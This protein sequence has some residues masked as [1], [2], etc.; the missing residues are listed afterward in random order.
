MSRLRLG[1]L[2]VVLAMLLGVSNAWSEET[3]PGEHGAEH[4]ADHHINWF[5]GLIG[6]KEGAPP[7]LFWRPKGMPAPLGATLINSALL[8]YVLVRFGKKPIGEALKKRKAG[9]M[10]GMEDGAR[11]KRE[12]QDQLAHYEQKLTQID[13]EVT[14]LRREMREAGEAERKRILAEAKERHSR[15]QRDAR[16]LVEQELKAAHEG[17]L[18]AA[19]NAAIRSAEERL[20]RQITAADQQRLAEEYLGSLRVALEGRS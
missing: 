19:A 5:Y 14:R 11:M 17:L 13:D 16:L 15:M 3:A 12:A 1:S 18:Q 7:D 8:F 6:E 20:K 4:G 2:L 10:Q 9:I